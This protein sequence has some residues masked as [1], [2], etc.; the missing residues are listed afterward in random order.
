MV[1]RLRHTTARTPSQA[2]SCAPGRIPYSKSRGRMGACEQMIARLPACGLAKHLFVHPPCGA[3]RKSAQLTAESKP[4]AT[5]GVCPV[6][7][8]FDSLLSESRQAMQRP[9]VL[10]SG[11]A[12]ANCSGVHA[13]GGRRPRSRLALQLNVAVEVQVWQHRMCGAGIAGFEVAGVGSQPV[14]LAA[15]HW[16]Q[17]VAAVAAAPRRHGAILTCTIMGAVVAPHR[18]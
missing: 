3:V 12:S 14:V 16:A 18:N 8:Q 9:Q 10:D 17:F 15:A 2:N 7:N 1:A 6:A 4:H 5:A 11:D 13:A